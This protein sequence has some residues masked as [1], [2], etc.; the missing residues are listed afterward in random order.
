MRSAALCR[1]GLA[2]LLGLGL[3]QSRATSV[4]PLTLTEQAKRAAIIVRAKVGTATTAKEGDV[5]YTVYP[6]TIL[7]S[8]AGDPKALPQ[9]GD[10]PALYFLQGAQDLPKVSAGQ[11]AFLLLYTGKLDSPVVGFNQGFYPV[12]SG[13]VAVGDPTAPALTG[14]ITDPAI[15]DPAKLRDAL[16]AAKEGK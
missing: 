5:T 16:R 6:L 3:S 13:S 11:E 12:V 14:P 2:G 10:Q 4:T 15:T 9:A 1:W 7:E 8:I